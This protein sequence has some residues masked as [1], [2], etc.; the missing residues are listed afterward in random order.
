MAQSNGD[1]FPGKR[2]QQ[3]VMAKNWVEILK[4]KPAWGIPG[5]AVTELAALTTAADEAFEQVNSRL[6]GPFARTKN[7]EAFAALALKM[8]AMKDRYFKI[9]PLAAPDFISLGLRPRDTIRT[10][11]IEVTDLVEFVIVLRYIREINIDF[12][13]KGASHKAKPANHD[14]AVIIWD[15]LEKPPVRHDELN[16]H[17]L[18]TRTPCSLHFAESERGKTAYIAACWQNNRGNT[19]QWSEIQSAIIP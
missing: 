14:G 10:S 3:L 9:P 18:A 11:H 6:R 7:K 4:S 16:R 1:W 2:P 17:I 8:R 13:I 19:G 5:E 15:V 12:W